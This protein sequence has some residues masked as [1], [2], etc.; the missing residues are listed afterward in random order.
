MKYSSCS[1]TSDVIRLVG[2]MM[3]SFCSSRNALLSGLMRC[4]S[5]Y[6]TKEQVA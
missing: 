2:S 4:R 3:S 5:M 6:F 1:A